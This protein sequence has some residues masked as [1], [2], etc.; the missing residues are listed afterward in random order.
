MR[1]V[2]TIKRC[3]NICSYSRSAF[4]ALFLLL[5]I[6]SRQT[7]LHRHSRDFKYCRSNQYANW[8]VAFLTL[9]SLIDNAGITIPLPFSSGF[10]KNWSGFCRCTEAA[11]DIWLDPTEV[12]S[13]VPIVGFTIVILDKSVLFPF[14][15]KGLP[16]PIQIWFYNVMP[17]FRP[18]CF[19]IISK[20]ANDRII[21][22]H[23]VT[24]SFVWYQLHQ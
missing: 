10:K 2:I 11:A 15:I 18:Y 17:Q 22:T 12:V 16:S 7:E 13:F 21:S 1:D 14:Y 19:E 8:T 4:L 3:S 23:R 24:D 5:W 20:I 9:S 6:E